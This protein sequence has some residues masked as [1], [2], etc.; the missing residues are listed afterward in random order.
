MF[1]RSEFD[2]PDVCGPQALIL[3]IATFILW[4]VTAYWSSRPYSA[5]RA[6][7]VAY[8]GGEVTPKTAEQEYNDAIEKIDKMPLD[9]PEKRTAKAYAKQKLLQRLRE[10]MG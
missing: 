8:Q 10:S 6:E 4:K 7:P 5:P 1:G 3:V 2:L 9:E